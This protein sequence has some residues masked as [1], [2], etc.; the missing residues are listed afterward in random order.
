MSYPG[1]PPQQGC[2]QPPTQ[3][4]Y[5]QPPPQQGPYQQGSYP[6]PPQQG[7]Y[8]QGPYPSP[9]QQG[10][11]P[12][13]QGPYLQ[14]TQQGPYPAP[15]QGPY[16]AP[17]QGP[18]PTPQPGGYPPPPQ[19][20]PYP[21]PHGGYPP[22]HGPYLQPQPGTY[23]PQAGGYPPQQGGYPGQPGSYPSPQ[24]PPHGRYPPPPAG[25]YAPPP[26][27]QPPPG[28]WGPP[29]QAAPQPPAAGPPP[30]PPQPQPQPMPEYNSAP[31]GSSMPV[32]PPIDRGYRGS[33]KDFPGADPLKDVEVLRTAMKGFGT[34]ECAIIELL[35]S[36]TSKQ[37]VPLVAG[38]KTSFGKDLIKDLKAEISG[39]LEL[40]V[41]AMLKP[42]AE[43]DAFEIRDAIRGLT[44]D[45]VCLIEILSSRTNAEIQEINKIFK[46]AFEIPLDKAIENETSGHFRRLLISLAQGNR[47]EKDQPD[48]SEVKLDAQKLY[49]AGE[50]RFGADESQFNAILCAR[51]TAHLKA[52]FHEYQQMCGIP[53]E[54]SICN[55]MSGNLREGMLAVVKCIKKSSVFFAEGLHKALG[56]FAV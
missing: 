14:P 48:E 4:G 49:E 38:Y 23:P 21:Q 53:I 2:P 44:T 43:L 45:E 3:Q 11:Y 16:P 41:L 10:G 26:G 5:P 35:G 54:Q 52:V 15:Q 12:A 28:G 32:A 24:P 39:N 8:Q 7:P 6:P 34:D 29:G 17:Q 31:S 50:D 51:S 47:A 37:R 9:P 1:Y 20:G 18:Y 33:I 56:I 30:A 40:L 42:Q 46:A 36:R 22:Q 27:P 13:Q 19:Q 55:E 25:G